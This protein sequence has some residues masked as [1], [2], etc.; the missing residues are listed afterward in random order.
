MSIPREVLDWLLQSSIPS[1]RYLTLTELIDIS[2]EDEG[3]KNEYKAIQ[4][5]H[6]ASSILE[7]QVASGRWQLPEHYYSPK[8]R[9][10]H[11]T[12][13]LL[14]ELRADPNSTA[15]QDGVEFMLSQSRSRVEHYSKSADPGF[16]CLFGNILRYAVYAGFLPDSR[17][18]TLIDVVTY[19]LTNADCSCKYNTDLPCSWGAARSLWGLAA[20]P[21]N[22]HT[23]SMR[24]S[25]QAG[26]NFLLAKYNLVEANYPFPEGGRIHQI[27]NKLNFPLFYQADILFVLRVM[28]QLGYAQQAQIQ[29]ALTWLQ[30]RQN[31]A[32][33]WSGSS[34]FQNR[35]WSLSR[36][37]EDTSRWV[38]LQSLS[39]LK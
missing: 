24:K 37:K 33:R 21:G 22:M 17:T 26:T 23:A 29:P 14:E 27:W 12:L 31:Q 28:K 2:P 36:D 13:M 34:P 18:Q 8:Y 11:W 6:P 39:V 25:I 19:S 15:F 10:T 20:I 9:S 3:V 4:N 1:I 5:S 7:K 35:T 32:G 30:S 16:T 38:T